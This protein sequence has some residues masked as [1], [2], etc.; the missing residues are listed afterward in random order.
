M[1]LGW[2]SGGYWWSY[3]CFTMALWP[4]AVLFFFRGDFTSTRYLRITLALSNAVDSSDRF[5][6]SQH[7]S[8]SVQWIP[9]EGLLQTSQ[10]Q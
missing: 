3:G 10:S 1:V 6:P 8:G 4:M 5:D 2:F 9:Q 7:P